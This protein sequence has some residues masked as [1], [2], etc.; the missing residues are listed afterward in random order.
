MVLL[1]VFSFGTH[2][3]AQ[4]D[5][6]EDFDAYANNDIPTDWSMITNTN[7]T[8]S[9]YGK[10]QT[11]NQAPTPLRFFRI[12]NG[13]ATSGDLIF[14]APQV[15]ATSDGN[16]RVKFWLQGTPTSELELGTIDT[17]DETGT[18]SLITNFS[19]S[20]DW[21][22]YEINIPAGT[23]QYLA[24]KHNM[25]DVYDQINI[26]SVCLQEI[27]TCLE[28]SDIALSNPTITT[29]DLNWNESGTG[30]DNWEYVVQ[31]VGG[32]IPT[33][34]GT[35]YSSTSATPS[36]TVTG[37]DMDTD[38]EAYVR[39][40]CG[41]GDYGEWIY[42][43]NTQR[44]NCGLLTD[45]FCEDWEGI[46]DNTVPF[47]WTVYD[48]PATSGHAYVDYEYTHSKNMFE[49]FF[50]YNT[51][52]G[53]IV[54]ISPDATFAMDGAHRINFTAG[55]STNVPDLLE[56]GTIDT[57]GNFVLLT[58]ITPTAD[59]DT[60]YLVD[61]PNNDHV[62]FA[63]R[64]GGTVNKYIWI[65]TVC[66]EDIPSCLEVNDVTASNVQYD[67]ADISWTASGS[68]E[69][70]WEY[71]VQETNLPAPDVTVNGTEIMTTSV[72]V[73][74]S[75][76]TSYIAYVR[77]KC[78]AT[79]FGAWI[80]STAFTSA[81]DSYVAEYHD[82]FEGVNVNSEEI[83][84]C[85]SVFDTTNGDLKTFATSY[86]IEPTEGSLML[87]FYFA[88]SAD[89]EGL[90]LISPEF[91]DITIDKQL[92]F[93]MNKRTG[94]ESEFDLIVGTVA[95]PN[96]MST[97]TVLDNTSLNETSI[98]ADTWTEF[99]LD[100][101]SY[102]TSLDHHYVVFKPQHSGTGS[103]LYLFMDEFSYEFNPTQVFND[104]VVTANVLTA[105]DDYTCNNAITGDYSGATQST[106]FPCTSSAYENY[107]DLWYRF[108][109][110]E[111]GEYAFALESVSGDPM[112]MFIFEGSSVE[113]IPL[114]SGCSTSHSSK[115]LEAGV[116]YFV[117]IASE[118]PTA[119]FS[120]C[121]YKFPEVPT[122]DEISN[123]NVLL[124]SEDNTCNNIMNGYTASASHSSD[125]A[126]AQATVDVWY[127]FVP[128][129][130]GEYTFRRRLLNGSA[131][132]GVSIYSGTPG[133]LTALTSC[134]SQQVL[135]DLVQGEQ[136]YV[137]VS[138]SETSIPMYFT[139]CAYKSPPAPENDVCDTPTVLTVGTTFEENVL[140]GTNISATIDLENTPFPN[141]GTL[142][143]EEYGRDVWFEVIVP[144]SGTFVVE[145][146]F[147]DDSLLTDTVVETYTGDCGLTTLEPFTYILPA[148]T[149]T[150]CSEQF[151]IG[152]NPF[153]G[154]TFT[155][156]QPGE[157]VLVRVWG[158]ARQFGNFRIS[159]YDPTETC[160]YPTDVEISDITEST[161]TISWSEVVPAPVGG[162]E[163]L[164]Q[165]ADTGY[166]G[167]NSG[168]ITSNTTVLVENLELGT[169]YEV[170]VKSICAAN[171]SAWDG[172]FPFTTQ[173]LGVT[174][175]TLEN[176]N[177]YPNPV[178]NVLHV[179]YT[180]DIKNVRVYS[181][182]G[183]LLFTEAIQATTGTI[184]MSGLSSGLYLLEA[185][186]NTS[187][188]VFKVFVK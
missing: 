155:D 109:P 136:Y 143:F 156:K 186:T 130:T 112:N 24:F 9:V 16:H 128:A 151:V 59:R 46:D 146:R 64:H 144:E 172:P 188:L 90:A 182:T 104:E 21:V 89:P 99:T 13:D 20:N 88:T 48:D 111:S 54:A 153:A 65:N 141:C 183:K 62:S 142:E 168:V 160:L 125:S 50:G 120:L 93:K 149:E 147:E 25:G 118:V 7:G 12:Y 52:L 157:T 18:F 80:A 178:S 49:L 47:C 114:S 23:N 91:T 173:T 138:S 169:D 37:L 85:W 187:N 15:A 51:V 22:Y 163:Y 115:S 73:P 72:A 6:S 94:N 63:F 61:L 110:T 29:L 76:N 124:E 31:E 58:T 11:S 105:S 170:Y 83:K 122:N 164:V 38:Y 185:Q 82:S 45:N 86:G 135:A 28:V 119:Q 92:R 126:C 171:E 69:T 39:S 154:M 127:T 71:L 140:V 134:G 3:F 43:G 145:T 107:N 26:D 84:P 4:C 132:T 17:N 100:F 40:D 181:L 123:P 81:C 116:T 77:A 96:D 10:V 44:T 162:Y 150:H 184:N 79:D 106:E 19:L 103:S 131:V 166:P 117:S 167:T 30:E 36:V 67:S 98:V 175:F 53:D 27:P 101:S 177:F 121:V 137:A 1:A 42:T 97:F 34:N 102:D 78:D 179:S 41:A 32:G 55:G 161:A 180:E 152:G 68:E 165:L 129:E 8:S 14:V 2:L 70:T 108:T 57:A 5:V 159:A 66:V 35:S 33:A 87:R 174:D 139:L 133:N 113:L 176:F 75:Q 56:V 95:D 148:G 74:L 60:Q 158:W